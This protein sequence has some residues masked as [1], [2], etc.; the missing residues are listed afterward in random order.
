MD[1]YTRTFMTTCDKLISF[2][3][4]GRFKFPR[5]SELLTNRVE[6]VQYDFCQFRFS[7]SSKGFNFHR[8]WTT[9]SDFP[10]KTLTTQ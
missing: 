4:L 10:E 1:E 9:R 3:G 8:S 6:L 2:P 5:L 7:V